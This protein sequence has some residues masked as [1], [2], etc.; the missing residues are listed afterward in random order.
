MDFQH[1][2]SCTRS[3]KL[4]SCPF[5]W[6]RDPMGDPECSFVSGT[7]VYYEETK[8]EL[9]RILQEFSIGYYVNGIVDNGIRFSLATFSCVH[10]SKAGPSHLT[11]NL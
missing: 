5:P 7:F 8:R 4:L 9:K 10:T 11:I 6:G 2:G 1:A 3:A